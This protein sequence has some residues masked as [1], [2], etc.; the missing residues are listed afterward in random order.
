M[1]SFFADKEVFANIGLQKDA[2]YF[3]DET[4]STSN[5]AREF[6]LN[7]DIPKNMLFAA[8]AQTSGRGTRQRSFESPK[9]EGL[10][11]SLL[12]C[13]PRED[14]DP[15][16]ITPLAAAAV[17]DSLLSL[18]G[19]EGCEK[20]FIKWVNDIY[21]GG[22]KVAGILAERVIRADG[23][24]GYI[25]GIGINLYG[26][27]F[28]PELKKTAASI[29]RQT[30]VRLDG[31]RLLFE[32]TKRLLASLPSPEKSSLLSIYRERMIPGGTPVTVTDGMG[33]SRAAKVVGLDEKFRLTVEYSDGGCD[34]LVS[35]DIAIKI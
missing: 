14:L 13:P 22:K 11:F 23:K 17:F 12:F 4:D 33:I 20:A 6:F 25:I 27:S 16:A 18:L 3:Y 30:G 28:T 34:S 29:E 8:D 9:G 19:E 15:S 21:F 7:S 24:V 26:E 31:G 32:I 10:Y 2:I 35:G 1:S 5:R